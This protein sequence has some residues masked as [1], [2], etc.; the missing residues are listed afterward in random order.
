VLL[1]RQALPGAVWVSARTGEGLEAL[2][3]VI[4][5]RLPHPAVHV[6]V[7]VPYD[8]GDLVAKVHR[9]GE[10]LEEVHEAEGTRLVAQVDAGL[11]ALL[12]P[13]PAPALEV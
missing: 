6:E 7:L 5:A 9:D 10:V 13:Y 1:L 11:A 4:A 12:E 3:D 8:R 2:R